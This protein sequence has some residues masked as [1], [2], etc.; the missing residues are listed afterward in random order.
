MP[1]STSSN[2]TSSSI[3]KL[4]ILICIKEMLHQTP[5]IDTPTHSALQQDF[6]CHHLTHC[7]WSRGKG[8][9]GS[10]RDWL[11]RSTDS[12][13][14]AFSVFLCVTELQHTTVMT[15]KQCLHSPGT[16]L[17]CTG[18]WVI[19]P[20]ANQKNMGMQDTLQALKFIFGAKW[21]FLL[22]IRMRLSEK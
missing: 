21:N 19:S 15:W 10:S 3:T 17:S 13:K 4:S 20:S 8:K 1:L 16:G 9:L 5:Q 7:V 18:R 2:W 6:L 12:W 14:A 11:L 22:G